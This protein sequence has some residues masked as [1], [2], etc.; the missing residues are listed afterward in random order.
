MRILLV[1]DDAVT[2]TALKT[3]LETLQHNVVTAKNGREGWEF[4][5]I[6]RYGAVVSDWNMPELDGLGLCRLIRQLPRPDY[7]YFIMMT[8]RSGQDDYLAAMAMGVDDFIT[9]GASNKELLIRLH[10]AERIVTYASQVRQLE[11]LLPICSYCKKIRDDQ[12]YWQQIE[13][14]I[15]E[16]TGTEFSHGICPEC[17]LKYLKP[18][19]DDL[20][21]ERRP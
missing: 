21:Q 7:P 1:E 12:N 6:D 16:H 9:K 11:S 19:F 4:F 17:Y 3:Q 10:V 5:Q 18:Q 14:Y 15:N 20:D 2:R 8:A 13:T